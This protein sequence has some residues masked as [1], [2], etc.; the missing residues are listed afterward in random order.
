MS[1]LCGT[2]VA[3]RCSIPGAD[4]PRSR[5]E[6]HLKLWAKAQRTAASDPVWVVTLVSLPMRGSASEEA[7]DLQHRTR[8]RVRADAKHP[9]RSRRPSNVQQAVGRLLCVVT[10]G[11]SMNPST[12]QLLEAARVVRSRILAILLSNKNIIPVRSRWHRSRRNRCGRGIAEGLAAAMQYDPGSA[13][14]VVRRR[15][16]P[17][18]RLSRDCP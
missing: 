12:A 9:A 16:D 13:G 11:Q 5:R 6:P 8:P 1:Q 2:R 15:P 7:L 3:L 18:G 14:F 17:R 4:P 10:G